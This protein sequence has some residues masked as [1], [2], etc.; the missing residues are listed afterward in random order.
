[1]SPIPSHALPLRSGHFGSKQLLGY[2]GL[3]PGSKTAYEPYLGLILKAF[4]YH[5]ELF[6]FQREKL[7]HRFNQ[8]KGQC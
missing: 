6:V 1:M 5:F 8:T 2:K 4:S 7:L 3:F